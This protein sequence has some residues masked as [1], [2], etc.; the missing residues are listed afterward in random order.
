MN[1]VYLLYKHLGMCCTG[2]HI[3]PIQLQIFMYTLF[4]LWFTLNT[5][6]R[7]LTQILFVSN[8]I[9]YRSMKEISSSAF[10]DNALS[11]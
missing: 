1:I 10:P 9:L 6:Y 4:T 11:R 3:V 8:T 5:L 2:K 7:H